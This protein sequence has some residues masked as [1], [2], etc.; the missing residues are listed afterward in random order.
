MSNY[1]HLRNQMVR[2]QIVGR[3][4]ND[5]DVL[6]AMRHVPREVFVEPGFEESA[7]DDRALPIRE[8]QT[9]SQPY[10]VALMIQAAGV[11]PGDRVLEIGAGSGYAAAVMGRIAKRVY[12]VERHLSLANQAKLRFRELGYHNISVRHG[13]GMNGW[14]EA[15]PFQAILV[16]AAASAVPVALK[17]QLAVGGRLVIPVGPQ[18][19]VQTLLKITRTGVEDFDEENLGAVLFV[20]LLGE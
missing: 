20:P 7:Y 9:I 11:R 3:G 15:A 5:V 4:L 13:D 18:E 8:G 16:A 6:E 14:P 17:L 1:T 10:I 19:R 2:T 12:A